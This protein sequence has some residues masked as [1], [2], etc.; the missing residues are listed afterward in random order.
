MKLV[1]KTR[2]KFQDAKSDK[3]YEVD[4][5]EAGTGKYLVNFRYGR[6]GANLK[7]GTKTEESVSLE[8]AEK[9]F[10]TLVNSKKKKG[11]KDESAAAPKIK[12]SV[13]QI[14][15][16]HNER[17]KAILNH[18]KLAIENPSA[19]AD[20]NWNI[21]RVMWRAGELKMKSAT[22]FI[23]Q[24][25]DTGDALH[26]YSALWALGRCQAGKDVAPILEHYRS[27]NH[28][29]KIKRIATAVSLDI[30]E[31]AEKRKLIHSLIAKIPPVFKDKIEDG[32]ISSFKNILN[33][34]VNVRQT[35][36]FDFLVYLYLLSQEFPQIKDSLV[37]AI[38][39]L[40]FEPPYFKAIRS[41]FKISEYRGDGQMYGMLA[42]RFEKQNPMFHKPTYSSGVWA[43]GNWIKNVENEIKKSNS[44]IAYSNKTKSYINRRIWR[45][46]NK[47]T[48][49]KDTDYIKIAT[50]ILLSYTQKDYTR[51]TK[52]TRW[53]Y[54]K[55][56]R[57]FH[58]KT[59]NYDSFSDSL[60]LN[61]ILYA[62]SSRYEYDKQ[63]KKWVCSGN[64]RPGQPAPNER[65]EACPELWDKMP[66]AYIH[67]L[68]ESELGKIHEFALHRFKN[69]SDYSALKNKIDSDLIV[70]F[71]EKD[72]TPTAS[73]ALELAKEKYD[74]KNPNRKLTLSLISSKLEKARDLA[75]K[76]I[77]ENYDFYFSNTDF[78]LSMTLHP[79]KDIRDWMK[80]DMSTITK[81]LTQSQ[82]Q[83]LIGR[84]IS[85]LLKF[86]EN[87]NNNILA[88][89]YAETLLLNFSELLKN[90]GFGIIR[91]LLKHPLEEN[92]KFAGELTLRHK[93]EAE[94]IPSDIFESFLN[95]KEAYLRETGIKLFGQ[96][97]DNTLLGKQDELVKYATSRLEDVR[98]AV[99][100]VIKKLADKHQS[101]A[102]DCVNKFVPVLLRK[103]NYEGVH[104]D[105]YSL[106]I[107]ELEPHLEI[108]ERK[109]IFRLLNSEHTKAQELGT[110]LVDKYIPAETLSVKNIVR[111]GT[112]E[113]QA[114]RAI[115]WRMFRENVA[116]I[117]YERED[118]LRIMDSSW[119][120]TRAFAFEFFRKEFKDKDWTPELLV[121]ICDSVRPDVSSFGRELITKFFKEE[122]GTQYLLQLSQHPTNELQLFATNYLERY[123][124][125]DLEKLKELE[126]YF[127]TVLSQV[128]KGRT[129]KNR[130]LNFLKKEAMKLPEA[131]EVVAR[132]LERLSL[133]VAIG[134]KSTAIEM[135]RDIH[136]KYPHIEVPI[137][138]KP[139]EA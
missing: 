97:S 31:G 80:K 25:H 65:E 66:K 39:S 11:Y 122:H 129:A 15:E 42:Y 91:D 102:E 130:V 24:L 99:K 110:V 21:R 13:P 104:E 107:S 51:P 52:D 112:H 5:C 92:K 30:L 63:R 85:H 126:F 108:I 56:T 133:T 76:W 132:I 124:S 81:N 64:Y 6:R 114:C 128:N 46:L 43:G 105:I 58:K 19:Q 12:L 117:K 49:E 17:K 113:I 120:D 79:Q 8:K 3:V 59:V 60:F 22:P 109:K 125:D 135:M 33:E 123:A 96:F 87:K 18:L 73:W 36:K 93:T 41:I 137:S 131:A 37:Q 7:E 89:D 69:H 23:A 67:L 119:D 136:E 14:S 57:R 1:K 101:F 68:A 134:D 62:N 74:P 138:L 82:K 71:I 98:K 50:G 100:P 115:S 70:R 16:T 118:A 95:A 34:H 10:D 127:V 28:P 78:I 77:S 84:I 54:S 121:S 111:L 20:K 32:N 83:V 75:K 72:Y 53:N 48:Q 55:K 103:E 35:K 27:G 90:I 9:I 116:R 4:L 88:K 40:K 139:I 106:L 47:L 38:K 94:K 29:E 45:S 26:V 61:Y 2:L 44:K 86:D